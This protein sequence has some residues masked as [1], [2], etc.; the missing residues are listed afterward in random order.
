[1]TWLLCARGR[2]SGQQPLPIRSEWTV[3]AKIIRAYEKPYL[4]STAA[5]PSGK[6]LTDR[7]LGC[8]SW[9]QVVVVSSADDAACLPVFPT[10]PPLS[11]NPSPPLHLVSDPAL[12]SIN[13][14]VIALTATDSLMHLGKEEIS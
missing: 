11:Q 13:G 12:L 7:Y 5:H 8:R 3:H 6:D 4:V 9:T 14:L 10:P 2:H 1:M